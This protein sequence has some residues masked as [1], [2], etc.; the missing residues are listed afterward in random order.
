MSAGPANESSPGNQLAYFPFPYT[1]RCTEQPCH[2]GLLLVE[3]SANLFSAWANSWKE[4]IK[5]PDHS[6]VFSLFL[7][8]VERCCDTRTSFVLETVVD[9]VDFFEIHQG[10]LSEHVIARSY[11]IWVPLNP[12]G[13]A[14]ISSS[15][16]SAHPET[17]NYE[18]EQCTQK[19]K[20]ARTEENS[21]AIRTVDEFSRALR[22]YFEG[23]RMVCSALFATYGFVSEMC[24]LQ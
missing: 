8:V 14:A 6:S 2:G 24:A 22:L 9:K 4:Y 18:L 12:I 13:A 21:L 20:R 11:R 23:K 3:L 19:Q 5:L 16:Q 15:F 17:V 7:S 1:Q 10:E